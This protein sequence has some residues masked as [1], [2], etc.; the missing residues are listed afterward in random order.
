LILGPPE[1]RT[2]TAIASFPQGWAKPVVAMT[3]RVMSVAAARS[4]VV[5]AERY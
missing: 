3:S 4:I 1:P 2:C 5:N